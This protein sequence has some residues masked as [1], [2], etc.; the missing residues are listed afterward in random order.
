MPPKKAVSQNTHAHPPSKKTSPKGV[1]RV[2]SKKTILQGRVFKVSS[3]HVREPGGIVAQREIVRHGPSVVVLA[4]DKTP[5][6]CILLERQYRHAAGEFLWELPAGSVD[7]G[8]SLLGA[9]KRELLEET[10]Y[11][12]RRWSRALHYYP[13]PGFVDETMTI[14]LAQGLT[15]GAASPEEDELIACFMVPLSQVVKMVMSGRIRDGKT[16][17]GVLW[18]AQRRDER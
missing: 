12:A 14:Y 17:A 9:A 5:D 1:A 13:T 11:R 6:P 8:E 10:G 3:E 18:L 15:S 4:V 7:P 2:L 16:I